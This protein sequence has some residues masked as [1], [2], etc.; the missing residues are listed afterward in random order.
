MHSLNAIVG[1]GVL[2]LPWA[3]AQLGWVAGPALLLAF[4]LITRWASILLAELYCV[5]GLEHARY[6]HA[7]EARGAAPLRTLPAGQGHARRG[8]AA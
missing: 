4:F 7:G 8:A 3:V 2:S 5:D 1:A 6:H